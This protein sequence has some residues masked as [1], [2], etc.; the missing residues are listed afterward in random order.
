MSTDRPSFA[1]D[2]A[3]FGAER[4]RRRRV[5]SVTLALG[6]AG[7]VALLYVLTLVRFGAGILDRP[8]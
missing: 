4:Q 1:E 2:V 6:L 7:L 5:R 3:R 8:L